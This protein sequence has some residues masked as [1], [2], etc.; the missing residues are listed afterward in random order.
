[1]KTIRLILAFLSLGV[2]ITS[3][4]KDLSFEG[5][6]AKGSLGKTTAGDCDP[7]LVNG[8]YYKDTTMKAS[9]F[10]DVQIDFTKIGIYN[11]KT[12]GSLIIQFLN[13]YYSLSKPK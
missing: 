5:G 7:I 1:M 3:C 10:V 12:L 4:Q 13:Q 9:N 8:L 2:A 11:I 6:N